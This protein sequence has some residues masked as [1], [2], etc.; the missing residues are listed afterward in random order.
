MELHNLKPA[1]RSTKSSKRIGR[2]EGSGKGGTSQKDIK[3][4]NPDQDTVVRLDSKEVKC[5]CTD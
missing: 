3:G 5:L 1:A 2:G 4:L